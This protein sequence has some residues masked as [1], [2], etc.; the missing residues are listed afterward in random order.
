MPE[1]QA[2]LPPRSDAVPHTSLPAAKAGTGRTA[3]PSRT[4]AARIRADR[5]QRRR[6]GA[7]RPK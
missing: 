1:R 2:K 7:D 5:T 3:S 4:D 6:E